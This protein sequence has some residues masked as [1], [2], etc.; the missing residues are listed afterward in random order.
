VW[1]LVHHNA[2]RLQLL[3][4]M[5]DLRTRIL[6][7]VQKGNLA[8]FCQSLLRRRRIAPVHDRATT[9]ARP[10]PQLRTGSCVG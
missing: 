8:Q 1:K 10:A 5:H 7:Y 9:A 2:M 6:S 3:G 4:E